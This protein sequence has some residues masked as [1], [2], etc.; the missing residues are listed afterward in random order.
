MSFG[1]RVAWREGKFLRPQHFQQQDRA[2]NWQLRERA[3]ALRPYPW[4]LTDVV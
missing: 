2:F 3:G 4:G 1:S